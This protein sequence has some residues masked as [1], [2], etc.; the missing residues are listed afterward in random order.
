VETI[1]VEGSHAHA[2]GENCVTNTYNCNNGKFT[3]WSQVE[4]KRDNDTH[5]EFTHT[6]DTQISWHVCANNCVFSC[7]EI[8][9]QIMYRTGP[10]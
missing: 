9:L 7:D 5:W 2:G 1:K 6:S 4:L 8:W 3:A 10:A